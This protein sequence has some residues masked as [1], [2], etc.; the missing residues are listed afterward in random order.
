ML[1]QFG[2]ARCKASCWVHAPVASQQQNH[3][4]KSIFKLFRSILSTLRVTPSTRDITFNWPQLDISQPHWFIPR[5]LLALYS[6]ARRGIREEKAP[7]W[8]KKKKKKRKQNG[9]IF[10]W[11]K[12]DLKHAG[13]LSTF[14]PDVGWSEKKEGISRSKLRCNHPQPEKK[15]KEEM[16]GT[17]RGCRREVLMVFPI[18]RAHIFHHDSWA[19]DVVSCERRGECLLLFLFQFV[20]RFE[21]VEDKTSIGAPRQ[22]KQGNFMFH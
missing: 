6:R 18:Y 17:Q 19:R 20:V 1:I 3:R 16:R 15:T 2:F 10:C 4:R 5:S 9:I 12:S 7:Q 13:D 8:N 21:W 14:F 22:I 11:L